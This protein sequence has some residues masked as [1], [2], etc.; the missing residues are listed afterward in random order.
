MNLFIDTISSLANI[1]I[2]DEDR[3][4]IDTI[5]WVVKWNESSTLIP[6]IDKL[7]K[8]NNITYNLLENI[9]TVNWPW[10]FTWVRTTVLAANSINYITNN[11]MTTLNYFDLYKTYPIV[12]SSSKR[13]C[14]VQFEKN[15][16]IK[17]IENGELLNILN[18]K[19]IKKV[20]W[21]ANKELFPEIEILEKIDYISIIKEV[22]LDNLK[23]IQALYIK[24]PNIS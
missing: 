7:I 3:N 13:D 6:Q 15:S 10:S 23:Q 14:F 21:E 24:K 22:K 19:S 9:V 12:K 4:I 11:S 5:S 2:F 20:Y 8:K 16:E 17:I 1:T 18:E